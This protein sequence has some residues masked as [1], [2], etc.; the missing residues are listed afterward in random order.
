[1]K[2]KKLLIYLQPAV[3]QRLRRILFDRR[4]LMAG[5]V[6]QAVYERFANQKKGGTR[7]G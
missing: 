6:R 3:H 1:M 2:S 4:V 5:C 7:H